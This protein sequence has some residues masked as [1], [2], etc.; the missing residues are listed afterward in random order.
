MPSHHRFV[1]RRRLLPA[2][3]VVV[4]GTGLLLPDGVDAGRQKAPPFDPLLAGGRAWGWCGAYPISAENPRLKG[5]SFTKILHSLR[6]TTLQHKFFRFSCDWTPHCLR[7][8]F[9]YARRPICG[10]L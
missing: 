1:I 5:G 9:L 3:A 7:S 6:R 4:A 8:V 2:V 10:A